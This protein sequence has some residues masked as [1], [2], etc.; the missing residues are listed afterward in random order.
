[1][2]ICQR[3][4]AA[5]LLLGSVVTASAFALGRSDNP[6]MKELANNSEYVALIDKSNQL[7][8]KADSINNLL[9]ERRLLLHSNSG[10]DRDTLR[11]EIILLEQLAHDISVEQGNVARRIGDIEQALIMD[12]ILS[13]Q[14]HVV[15][16]EVL[17]DSIDDSPSTTTSAYLIDNECFKINLSEEDYAELQKAQS[18]ESEMLKLVEEYQGAYARILEVAE[19]YANAD[20]ASV[21][22]PLYEEYKTLNTKLGELNTKMH[23]TWN[24][25]LDTKYFAMSFILE[26]SHRYDILDR[27]STNYQTMQHTCAEKDGQYSSDALMRYAIGRST[28][29]SYEIE[30]ARDMRLKPAQDSLRGVLDKYSQPYYSHKTIKLEQ[31]EFMDYA[32]VKIGRTNFYDESNPLPELQVFEHGTIYRIRLGRYR[33]KQ[34]MTLF[35]GVQPMSIERDKENMYCY[36]AGGYAKE[37]EAREALQF[38]KDKG[39]KNPELCCWKD[40]KMTIITVNKPEVKKVESK[41]RYLVEINIAA[42]D[43]SMHQIINKEAPGKR[44]TKS[45]KIFIVGMFTERGEADAL[46]TA[47]IEAYPTLEMSITETEME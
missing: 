44:I 47:L 33:T 46:I 7:S 4:I 8:N 19:S 34:T 10:I 21:A 31:R 36:Y 45:G 1:M 24:H 9:S 40:G 29:L 28:L 35:K 32:P 26:K 16:G 37:S 11:T 38:I 43:S 15:V 39:I 13:Q 41:T 2:N 30:F 5:L 18:E 14:K 22:L 12:K 17:D 25:I 20:R 42:V 27:A 6:G 23:N 3:N